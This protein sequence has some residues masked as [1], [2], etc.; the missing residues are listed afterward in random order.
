VC[1]V[2][3]VEH[4]STHTYT[5][6]NAHSLSLFLTRRY[7]PFIFDESFKSYTSTMAQDGVWYV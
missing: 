5:L 4:P 3:V 7:A 1:H 2:C 6:Y